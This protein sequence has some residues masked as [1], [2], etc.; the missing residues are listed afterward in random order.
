MAG[1]RASAHNI[2]YPSVFCLHKHLGRSVFGKSALGGFLLFAGTPSAKANDW[3]DYNRRAAYSNWRL[4]EAIEHFGYY[5]PQAN[6]WRHER[7]YE[8][9]ERYGR[10]HYH[11]DREGY[12]YDRD[13]DRDQGVPPIKGN[14]A[15]RAAPRAFFRNRLKN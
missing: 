5:R 1:L 9:L 2:F 14:G 4:H 7:A 15:Q 6:H 3:D 13:S 8:R 12:R 10:R 11:R